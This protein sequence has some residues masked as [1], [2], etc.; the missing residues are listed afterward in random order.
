MT[1]RER[2]ADVLERIR[3]CVDKAICAAEGHRWW[4]EYR[5]DPVTAFQFC[6][7]CGKIGT[8]FEP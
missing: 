4:V 3:W 7:R 5:G 8:R 1:I 6:A 2:L